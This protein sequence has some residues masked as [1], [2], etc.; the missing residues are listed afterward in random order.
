MADPIVIDPGPEERARRKALSQWMT[1]PKL[2]ERVVA[3][4]GPLEGKYVLEPAC[5]TGNLAR[6][7]RAAG[8]DV[9]TIDIDPVFK[10][11]H[12]GD[13]RKVEFGGRFNL[14]ITNPPYEDGLE[15]DF[16][17]KLAAD[18]EEVVA[19]V[20][21]NALTGQKRHARLWKHVTVTGLAFLVARPSF[22]LV[23]EDMGSPQ[24][25]FCVVRYQLFTNPNT[26]IRPPE[27][28]TWP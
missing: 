1:D 12:V 5:G 23:D 3:W 27:W 18:A 6:A 8:A 10:P 21:V 15:L 24:H 20:R 11:E 14:A 22:K 4:A 28:W 26:I 17:E 7:A 13:Y 16:L 25:D 2:A 19:V 9:T